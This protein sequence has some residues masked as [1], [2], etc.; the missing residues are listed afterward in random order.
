[1]YCFY[2][3]KSLIDVINKTNIKWANQSKTNSEN[4]IRIY[5]WN[6][7]FIGLGSDAFPLTTTYYPMPSFLMLWPSAFLYRITYD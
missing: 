5:L 3:R 2:R 6:E 4:I 7:V 1:M